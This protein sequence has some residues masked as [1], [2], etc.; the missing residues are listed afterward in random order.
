VSSADRTG[1]DLSLT[2]LILLLVSTFEWH[3]KMLVS[4]VDRTGTDLSL[5]VLILLLQSVHLNGTIRCLC[6]LQIEQE[7]IYHLQ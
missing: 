6:H 3:N 1:T 2:V 5:T 7:Q 4:S